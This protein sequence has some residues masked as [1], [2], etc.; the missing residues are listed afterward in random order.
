MA[1]IPAQAGIQNRLCSRGKFLDPGMRRGDAISRK[2]N[3][4]DFKEKS[5]EFGWYQYF[6]RKS[7][8]GSDGSLAMS[9]LTNAAKDQQLVAAALKLVGNASGLNL[10]ALLLQI[11]FY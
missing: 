8:P 5:A 1:V 7:V 6:F 9:S 10:I 4:V 3:A 2:F 11:F